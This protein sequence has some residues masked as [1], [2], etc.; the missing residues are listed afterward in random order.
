MNVEI[1]SNTVSDFSL[2]IGNILLSEKGRFLDNIIFPSGIDFPANAYYLAPDVN[3]DFTKTMVETAITSGED[4]I[5]FD[6]DTLNV[7]YA[8]AGASYITFNDIKGTTEN[9][10]TLDFRNVYIDCFPDPNNLLKKYE[11][12]IFEDCENI[13]VKFGNVEGDK[14]KRDF[15]TPEEIAFENSKLVRSGKGTKNLVTDGGN[16]A[17]FMADVQSTIPFGSAAIDTNP[18]G[19]NYFL[20]GDGRYESGFYN[21]DPTLYPTFGLVGGLGYNRLLK[22]DMENVTFKFYDINENFISEITGAQYYGIYDF[23]LT[24][25]KIKVNVDPM[26]GRID[27]P[28]NFGHRLMYN[29]NFG[30]VVKNMSI[31]DNHRGG[32]GNIGAKARIENCNFFNTQRYFDVPLFSD[33]TRYHINCEDVVSRDLVIDNCTL[34][35]KA[36]KMLLTHNINVDVT[37]CTFTGSG[38]DIF[39]YDLLYGNITGNNFSAN[40]NLGTGTNKSLITAS[41]NTG[42]PNV[43][44]TNAV[45]WINNNLTGANITGK[46]KLINNTLTNCSYSALKWTKEM[47]GN[48]FIGNS[49]VNYTYEDSYI[50]NNTFND[51]NFRFQH[52][53]NPIYF[54]SITVDNTLTTTKV[55]FERTYGNNT[56]AAVNSTFKN[57]RIV[58]GNVIGD[59][60]FEGCTFQDVSDYIISLS[61]LNAVNFY[62]KDCNF[63]GSGN[64]VTGGVG[65]TYNVT[66]DNCTI[67][68]LITMPANSTN[69]VVTMPALVEPRTQPI[70]SIYIENDYTIVYANFHYYTLQIRNKN[71]QEIVLNK[72]VNRYY[73]HYTATPNDFEYSI[74]GGVYW[75]EINN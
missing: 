46:G 75:D 63:I 54:D 16:V 72:D 20:Q 25:R 45:N 60:Y 33:S 34:S 4:Y 47:Y 24:A 7:Y 55:C 5:V 69:A 42:S 21:V 50:F 53:G 74:D 8:N 51:T 57:V 44:L 6:A 64:F 19:S 73:K 66:F 58:N 31:S 30:T 48:T 9:P 61:T 56:I 71:T 40:V 41:L 35:D 27:S 13:I 65:G 12:F 43:T 18:E 26:D 14:F 37:N 10:I 39:I 59:W 38:E 3:G 36:N 15:L 32:S 2:A 67:D 1:G 11:V 17:G 62:F 22:Y 29:P 68:P 52:S 70:P 23:P 49:G 28:T